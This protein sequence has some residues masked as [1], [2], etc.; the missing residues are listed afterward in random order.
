MVDN[1]P[2]H[3]CLNVLQIL[4]QTSHRT[5]QMSNSNIIN[6]ETGAFIDKA[7]VDMWCVDTC[8]SEALCKRIN[9]GRPELAWLLLELQPSQ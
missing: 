6:A 1:S 5:V 8:K 2:L 4:I 7:W 3:K 9:K